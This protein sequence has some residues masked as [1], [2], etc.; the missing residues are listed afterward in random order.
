M[1]RRLL[2]LCLLLALLPTAA[3][4]EREVSVYLHE[5]SG[6]LHLVP[7]RLQARVGDVL[8]ITVLN[9]GAS[10]HNLLVCGD[11]PSPREACDERWGFTGL[12]D[13]NES[14]PLTATLP[15]AGTFHYWCYVPGHKGAGMSGEL[16]VVGEETHKTPGLALA[17]IMAALLVA[18]LLRRTRP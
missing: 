18:P 9:Q 8:R 4:V 6:G 12:L 1:T 11:A 17:P 10:P 3:A 15:R 16:V 14:A 5:Y 7:E 2:A 13:A